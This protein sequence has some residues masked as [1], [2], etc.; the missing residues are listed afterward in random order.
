M[1]NRWHRAEVGRGKRGKRFP[2][3]GTLLLDELRQILR[4]L[5]F[6]FSFKEAA[7]RAIPNGIS[8]KEFLGF[9]SHFR[10]SDL[11]CFLQ[12]LFFVPLRISLL[13]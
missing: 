2:S 10:I 1:R 13:R 4:K 9:R 12:L 8:A 11:S 3:D 5:P 7:I 6:S